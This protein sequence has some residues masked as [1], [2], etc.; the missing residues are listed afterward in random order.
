[1]LLIQ[2]RKI[3]IIAGLL[4]CLSLGIAQSK[5]WAQNQPCGTT[6]TEKHLSY[7]KQRAQLESQLDGRDNR[8]GLP[9][10][11]PVTFHIVTRSDGSGGLPLADLQDAFDDLNAQF[12][13][14]GAGLVFF[15]YQAI[16]YIADDDYYLNLDTEAEY[17]QLD[18]IHGRHRTLDI[19][20]VGPNLSL[21]SVGPICGYGTFPGDD[22]ECVLIDNDCATDGLTL[23][24]EV[25]HYLFLYH[26]HETA[27]G[28]EC[29][30]GSNCSGA[31]DKLC[32]TPADPL[33]S[34]HVSAFPACVYDNSV[35]TPDGCSG[36]YA[37]QTDNI[38]AYSRTPCQDFFSEDQRSKMSGVLVNT[39]FEHDDVDLDWFTGYVSWTNN[40]GS[41]MGSMLKPWTT[42]AQACCPTF[43]MYVFA[44][45]GDYPETITLSEHIHLDVW[46]P[47][48][49]PVRIG[50]PPKK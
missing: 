31:G 13:Q 41:E 36:T 19:F 1:M 9:A 48:E 33:L 7:I 45:S 24:H 47:S 10:Y 26:T 22:A 42:I 2:L 6:I 5:V 29:P 34:G 37:P 21:E 3:S 16:D 20:F 28:T 46:D 27:F 30:D 11:I 23:A 12:S 44:R 17:I 35:A 49:G 18:Q 25:G 14:V 43:E 50:T 4:I 15:Q 39:R 38:M 8:L 40:S 32:D